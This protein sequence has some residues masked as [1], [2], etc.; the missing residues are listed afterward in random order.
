MALK[1]LD[2]KRVAAIEAL[3]ELMVPG[4]KG[5]GSVVY[6]D[7]VLANMPAPVCDHAL[8]A[9]DAL[10]P[11]SGNAEAL[12]EQERTPEFAFIRALA[13]EAYYSD[14]VAPGKVGPSAW[15]E[16]DFAPPVA[17]RL[18]KDWSWLGVS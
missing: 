10:A 6:I 13:C 18:R 8:E 16:I 2:E 11:A 1:A 9:I 15:E 3:C 12:A 17:Q 7:A 14:F 4:S 5:V